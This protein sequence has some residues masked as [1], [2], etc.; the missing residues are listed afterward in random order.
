M[1]FVRKLL[2]VS[3]EACYH[4]LVIGELTAKEEEPV[5]K[6]SDKRKMKRVDCSVPIDGKKNSVFAHVKTIDFSKGGLGLISQDA[7]PLNKEI[8]V[9]IDLG[10]NQEPVLVRGKVKWV[11]PIK[12]TPNFRV[13]L[14][15]EDFLSGSQSRLSQYL[16]G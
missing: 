11:V 2:I 5:E 1:F 10:E 9:E 4:E 13:G 12:N 6:A 16:Q 8:A 3:F 14:S 7:I 15:F